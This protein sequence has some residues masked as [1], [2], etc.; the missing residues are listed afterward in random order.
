MVCRSF[1]ALFSVKMHCPRW[2]CSAFGL[3]CAAII[4]LRGIMHLQLTVISFAICKEKSECETEEN[5]RDLF[6]LWHIQ[7]ETFVLTKGNS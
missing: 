6:G 5:N 1:L 2:L 7:F 3:V 4:F